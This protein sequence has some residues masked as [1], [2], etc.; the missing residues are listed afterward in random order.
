MIKIGYVLRVIKLMSGIQINP[1]MI[2]DKYI[3]YL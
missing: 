1:Y 3:F 2:N